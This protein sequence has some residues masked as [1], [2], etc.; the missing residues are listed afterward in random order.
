MGR[1]VKRVAADFNWPLGKVWSGF[2]NPHYDSAQIEC[3]SCEGSG[4]SPRSE[5]LK[6]QWYGNEPFD[7][8]SKGSAPFNGSE[9]PMVERVRR[10]VE[11]AK[12]RN[13]NLDE[14]WETRKETRRLL[15][16]FNGQWMH[17]LSQEDVQALVDGD[18][19]TG[20]MKVFKPGEGWV[21]KPGAVVP[22]AAEVNLWSLSGMGHDSI[23]SWV[24]I[25]AQCEREGVDNMCP[26]CQ[27]HGHAW[28][29]E[30][31]KA[32]CEGWEPSEP[33]A[34]KSWQVWETVSEG[35]PISPAFEDPRE[36]A[37]WLAGNRKGSIDEGVSEEKWLAFIVGPGWAPSM[38]VG[39]GG[40]VSGVAAVQDRLDI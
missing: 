14:D 1:E 31:A 22:T 29:S 32:L 33:P 9:A 38:V 15:R 35:S 4:S 6:D 37:K 19:L 23:N 8:A 39:A 26:H 2:L 13:P 18:R 40:L 21:D 27:G 10:N 16:H 28:V 7:P 12:E 34:G 36:L 5:Y 17:H 11:W 20:F 30:E 3:A 25:S 24:V